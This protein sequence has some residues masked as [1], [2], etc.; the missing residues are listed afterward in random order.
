[1]PPSAKKKNARNV[2]NAKK[3][4]PGNVKRKQ[5]LAKADLDQSNYGEESHNN[6]SAFGE[7]CSRYFVVVC[8]FMHESKQFEF[9]YE[10]S[11][12]DGC[13]LVIFSM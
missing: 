13:V 8:V 2:K 12:W 1:M 11:S 7:H 4:K 6:K 3:R 9:W 10:D 5:S